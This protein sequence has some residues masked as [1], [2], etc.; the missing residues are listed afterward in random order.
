MFFCCCWF[1]LNLCFVQNTSSRTAYP[2]QKGPLHNRTVLPWACHVL[3]VDSPALSRAAQ[4]IW[5][6]PQT[7]RKKR[8]KS[9]LDWAL[10]WESSS[11]LSW[12]SLSVAVKRKQTRGLKP[13]RHDDKNLPWP[14]RISLTTR[15]TLFGSRGWLSR[16]VMR[17]WKWGSLCFFSLVVQ[18]EDKMAARA[19]RACSGC[20]L[21]PNMFR[22]TPQSDHSCCL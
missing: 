8:R 19:R 9:V 14:K 1:V 2:H 18:R 11:E 13:P 5:F 20:E 22:K 10:S 16:R 15:W 4:Q 21:N 17:S 6:L 12:Q 7:H 3:C